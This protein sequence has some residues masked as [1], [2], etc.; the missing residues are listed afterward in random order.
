M[1]SAGSNSTKLAVNSMEIHGVR[2]KEAKR[3]VAQFEGSGLRP[4]EF[5]RTHGLALSTVAA[6]PQKAALG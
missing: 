4:A 5:C 2:F 3:L 6:S 1:T